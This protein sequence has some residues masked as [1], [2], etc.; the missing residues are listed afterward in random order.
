MLIIKI[1]NNY[2][3]YF[4]IFIRNTINNKSHML[5]MLMLVI[6]FITLGLVLYN[7][8]IKDFINRKHVLNNE[9]INNTEK[10]TEILI[11]YFYTEW[12]PYC[13]QSMGELDLFEEYIKG[14]NAEKK[15]NITLT[16]IDC[17]KQTTLAD[18]YKIEGYPSIK[19][20]YQNNVY[21][22]DARPNK[23]SLIQ[24]LET[25]THYKSI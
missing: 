25:F 15:Y 9:F 6:L 7:N 21:D 24:F 18:K 20:I 13:K 2:Y 4:S 17:D 11:L 1:L 10:S 16:K 23:A 5:L 14:E 19:L 22:Y 3:E 8:S 12:C